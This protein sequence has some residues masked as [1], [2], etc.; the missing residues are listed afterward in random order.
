MIGIA[1]AGWRFFTFYFQL[2]LASI[3][4]FLLNLGSGGTGISVAPPTPGAPPDTARS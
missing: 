4:F 1:T 2:G 3:L